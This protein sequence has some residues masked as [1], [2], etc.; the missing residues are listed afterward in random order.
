MR[1]LKLAIPE[2]RIT[3]LVARQLSNLFEYVSTED[4]APLELAVSTAL[5]RLA[6]CFGP[7]RNKYYRRD[8]VPFFDVMHSGQYSIFLYYVSRSLAERGSTSLADR[9]YYLN[10]A[11][12]GLDLYHG[13]QMPDIF[14][15]DHPVGSVI[16]RAQIGDGFVFCQNC[17]V[18]NNRGVFPIIGREVTLFAGATLIGACHIGQNVILGAGTLVI[19][20]DVPP[21]SVVTGRS[22]NLTIR[23]MPPESF[24]EHSFFEWS[25][26]QSSARAA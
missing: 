15:L 16:G 12:N 20:A 14:Y 1:A 9:V 2:S 24:Q 13:V 8:G 26:E 4:Q 18:G 3:Q 17:T 10:K 19:D 6:V 25:V 22:P 21:F 5:Q 11:L 23:Q 7:C